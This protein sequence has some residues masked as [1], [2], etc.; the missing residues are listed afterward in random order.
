MLLDGCSINDEADYRRR[1]LLCSDLLAPVDHGLAASELA[2]WIDDQAR[3]I[4][5]AVVS[6]RKLL[7]LG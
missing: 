1:R 6:R 4:A 3:G 7:I 5:R 2:S